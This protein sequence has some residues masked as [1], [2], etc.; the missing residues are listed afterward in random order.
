MAA[1][2]VCSSGLLGGSVS[3]NS[4]GSNTGR[5]STRLVSFVGLA[6]AV[7]A[8]AFSGYVVLRYRDIIDSSAKQIA[9]LQE[10]I[11]HLRADVSAGKT[12][13]SKL[14]LLEPQGIKGEP[15]PIGL[16]GPK[17]PIGDTGP[18]GPQ[19]TSGESGSMG[20]PGKEG[21]V[22][23]KGDAGEMGPP[24]PQGPPGPPGKT[25]REVDT[26][27]LDSLEEGFASLTMELEQL[28]KQSG[29]LAKPVASP[30][31]SGGKGSL[32][33]LWKGTVI[34]VDRY[35]QTALNIRKIDGNI[36]TGT[37]EY[38]GSGSGSDNVKIFPSP[39]ETGWDF[40][41]NTNS[42]RVMDYF[43]NVESGIMSGMA[44]QDSGCKLSM[45]KE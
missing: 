36:Y 5:L 6:S 14:G 7:I 22:G 45:S 32:L 3:E 30:S 34:C 38:D 39:P 25:A 43:V 28:R 15:G 37:F 16:P 24:G 31:R 17:G 42:S 26:A 33:G 44:D 8:I 20:L 13:L 23:P 9:D 19:G 11:E 1:A 18:A 12:E 21:P 10:Q 4:V 41:F 27:R 40:R 35:F 29:D 2:A